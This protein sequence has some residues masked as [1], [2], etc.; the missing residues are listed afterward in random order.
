MIGRTIVIAVVLIF[1]SMLIFSV[2][3]AIHLESVVAQTAM[4]DTFTA[5]GVIS[6]LV[7]NATEFSDTAKSGNAS[8]KNKET[9]LSQ[10]RIVGTWKLNV[11]SGNVTDFNAM[12]T[13]RPTN[14][15]SNAQSYELTKF[16][17]ETSRY[18][19]LNPDGGAFILGTVSVNTNG[20][21]NWKNIGVTIVIG[22]P[23][24]IKIILDPTA[25]S[26]PFNAPINGTIDSLRDRTGLE[27]VS[28]L[29]AGANSNITNVLPP[30]TSSL[31]PI[32]TYPP[33]APRLPQINTPQ[34]PPYSPPQ[35]NT[36]QQRLPP[37][38]PPGIPLPPGIHLPPGIPLPPGIHL[39][40]GI[41]TIR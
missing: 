10:N 20:S 35:I 21:R 12:I 40:P 33:T 27:M 30:G 15:T 37:G 13:M 26:T 7:S 11:N 6:S 8:I 34:S 36:P 17:T 39:P 3:T 31:P 2:P 18:I 4:E 22:K 9:S 28:N 19:Q 5:R 29:T 25:I 32:G 24:I 14:K 41:P 1:I 16:H 23:N 38:I